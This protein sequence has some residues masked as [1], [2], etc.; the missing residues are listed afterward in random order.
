MWTPLGNVDSSGRIL[1]AFCRGRRS[2]ALG[3][4]CPTAH[5]K[6]T[7]GG[8]I[9][10]GEWSGSVYQ[11]L[12]EHGHQ[13]K[14]R[15]STP[16]AMIP[17]V[18]HLLA[19]RNNCGVNIFSASSSSTRSKYSVPVLCRSSRQQECSLLL[20]GSNTYCHVS[21]FSTPVSPVENFCIALATMYSVEINMSLA[22]H[23]DWWQVESTSAPNARLSRAARMLMYEVPARQRCVVQCSA[24]NPEIWRPRRRN[25]FRRHQRRESSH[26]CA[27]YRLRDLLSVF[28]WNF[29]PLSLQLLAFLGS[30]S[31]GDLDI[32]PSRL[33]ATSSIL[34]PRF[35]LPLPT[36][37]SPQ[38]PRCCRG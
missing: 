6:G 18:N 2:L 21:L 1:L 31:R 37:F 7:A 24:L 38:A 13:R 19:N 17:R 12:I 25:F 20:H 5:S 28:P 36:L 35:F 26:D 27:N 15:L 16:E 32:P 3:P 30:P 10:K 4:K 14:S 8:R 23:V 11:R 22:L 9:E 34:V 33:V 29:P